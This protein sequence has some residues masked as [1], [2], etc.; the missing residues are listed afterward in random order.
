MAQKIS[1]IN[2]KSCFD[3]LVLCAINYTRCLSGSKSR[4]ENLTI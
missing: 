4:N 1:A 2:K 3:I